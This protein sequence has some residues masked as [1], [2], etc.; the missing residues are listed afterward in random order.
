V[1]R[2]PTFGTATIRRELKGAAEEADALL[3]AA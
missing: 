3:A 2:R 1:Y